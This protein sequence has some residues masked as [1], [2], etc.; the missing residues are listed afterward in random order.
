VISEKM[1]EER[2]RSIVVVKEPWVVVVVH[3]D[4]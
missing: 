4:E 2:S 1:K 3:G